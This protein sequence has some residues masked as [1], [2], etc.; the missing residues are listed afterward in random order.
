ME[1]PQISSSL[2][3]C[4]RAKYKEFM[5][6][7]VHRYHRKIQFKKYWK[8]LCALR[9]AS[10]M[11]LHKYSSKKNPSYGCEKNN[12][13]MRWYT[14]T[15][16]QRIKLIVKSHFLCIKCSI[17]LLYRVSCGNK[18][19]LLHSTPCFTHHQEL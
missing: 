10:K 12:V 17:C 18:L 15:Y 14:I 1:Q 6:I 19:W 16:K 11:L 4:L 5:K 2:L 7:P 3:L 9:N 8:I 13:F